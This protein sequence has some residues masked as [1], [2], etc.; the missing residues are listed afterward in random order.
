LENSL[1][2]KLKLEQRRRRRHGGRPCYEERN[3]AM[4]RALWLKGKDEIIRILS[5]WEEKKKP[6]L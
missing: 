2:K 5:Y 6:S 1:E 4:A 3:G